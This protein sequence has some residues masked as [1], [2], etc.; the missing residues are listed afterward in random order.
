MVSYR[1]AVIQYIGNNF[2]FTNRALL[3]S[4]TLESLPPGTKKQSLPFAE[5]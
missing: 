1:Q 4:D 2:T 5:S 3:K